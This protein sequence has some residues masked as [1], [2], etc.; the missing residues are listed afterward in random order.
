VGGFYRF[1]PFESLGQESDVTGTTRQFQ[2]H[3]PSPEPLRDCIRCRRGVIRHARPVAAALCRH[4]GLKPLETWRGKPA[5]TSLTTG[6][7]TDLKAWRY[8]W[9]TTR[10]HGAKSEIGRVGGTKTCI[11][12][13]AAQVSHAEPGQDELK[14][15]PPPGDGEVH[16]FTLWALNSVHYPASPHPGLANISPS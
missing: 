9:Q 13:L 4:P 8:Q 5:A 14:P 6:S 7:H 11:T 2:L 10:A 3:S 1:P 16:A 12:V 15:T